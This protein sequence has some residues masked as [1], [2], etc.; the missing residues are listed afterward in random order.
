MH[1]EHVAIYVKDLEKAKEFF[2]SY[3]NCTVNDLYHNK[4]TGFK[5]YFVCFDSGARLEIMTRDNLLPDS[6]DKTRLGYVHLALCVGG[7]ENVDIY[8][9]KL[10]E[11]GYNVLSGPR[12][13]GDGYYESVVEIFE[14][15]LLELCA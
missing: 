3:F 11:N 4:N 6:D 13:T 9:R 8:T 1:I 12:V 15:N 7:R 5:S 2:T 14:G 10:Q